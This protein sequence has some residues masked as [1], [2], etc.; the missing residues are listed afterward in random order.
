MLEDREQTVG[1]T[2]DSHGQSQVL[3]PVS[4][5]TIGQQLLA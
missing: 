3:Y 2:T 5:V 1:L 4:D